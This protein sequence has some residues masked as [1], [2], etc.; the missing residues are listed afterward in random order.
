MTIKVISN[1][2]FTGKCLYTWLKFICFH[3]KLQKL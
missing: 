1:V 3:S 2:M